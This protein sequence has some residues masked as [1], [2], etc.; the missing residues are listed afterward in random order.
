MLS[1]VLHFLCIMELHFWQV[2]NGWLARIGLQQQAQISGLDA[3]IFNG[4]LIMWKDNRSTSVWWSLVNFP[5]NDVIK[6][7]TINKTC[8]SF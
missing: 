5:G 3:R 7:P 8:T 6:F 2:I 4:Y 1:A